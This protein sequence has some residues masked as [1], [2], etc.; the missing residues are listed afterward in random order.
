MEYKMMAKYIQEN[1]IKLLLSFVYPDAELRNFTRKSAHNYVEVY[2]EEFENKQIRKVDFLPD[3]I[4]VYTEDASIDGEP[5]GN[6]DVLH[7]YLQLMVAKGY[8]ELWKG[9]PYLI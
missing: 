2:Y 3:D 4:Y 9:N 1:E 8:S 6:G 5:I 7:K